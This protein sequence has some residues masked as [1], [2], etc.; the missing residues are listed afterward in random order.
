MNR[1]FL[2][3]SIASLKEITDVYEQQIYIYLK[4]NTNIAGFCSSSYSAIADAIGICRAKV[5]SV[6][7]TLAQKGLIKKERVIVLNGSYGVNHYYLCDIPDF[8]QTNKRKEMLDEYISIIK[9]RSDYNNGSGILPSVSFSFVKVFYDFIESKK[10]NVREKSLYIALMRYRNSKTGFCFPSLKTLA[11]AT[12]CCIK[13]VSKYINMLASKGI[14]RKET[15]YNSSS[16]KM[17]SCRYTLCDD[18]K[19]LGGIGS[20]E[21]A[22]D[23]QKKKRYRKDVNAF[24][25]HGASDRSGVSQVSIETI[26]TDGI[27]ADWTDK[28]IQDYYNYDEVISLAR[29]QNIADKYVDA[30]FDI[31]RHEFNAKSKTF[32][33]KGEQLPHKVLIAEYQKLTSEDIVSAISLYLQQNNRINNH[34]AYLKILLYR[35]R[36]QSTLE[37]ANTV[38]NILY[39][40]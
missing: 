40:E 11:S 1:Q 39:N 30:T 19:L 28:M 34:E 7:D 15:Y 18:A 27:D 23:N 25:H 26:D 24:L 38:N 36:H 17:T 21:A 2:K 16:G 9:N 12:D 4:K 20:E 33:Y 31:I 5:I 22:D 35:I 37:I 13:T 14:I 29:S 10:L 32:N 8:W 3:V 6:I